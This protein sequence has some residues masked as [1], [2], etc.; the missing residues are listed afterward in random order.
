MTS[1]ALTKGQRS[2]P[3]LMRH[4]SQRVVPGRTRGFAAQSAANWKWN[5]QGGKKEEAQGRSRF[6]KWVPGWI[7]SAG[8]KA[9]AHRLVRV[10]HFRRP[11]LTWRCCGDVSDRVARPYPGRAF[12]WYRRQRRVSSNSGRLGVMQNQNIHN[13]EVGHEP[14]IF[15]GFW[16]SSGKRSRTD[17]ARPQG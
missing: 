10:D 9:S 12:G 17:M 5:L 2:P 3:N 14:R 16:L 15:H 7:A 4:R 1:T 6:T 13:L 11:E 8:R